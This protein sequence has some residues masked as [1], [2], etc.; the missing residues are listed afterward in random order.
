MVRT[1]APNPEVGAGGGWASTKPAGIT[2]KK[3]FVSTGMPPSGPA[4][5]WDIA[6]PPV[7]MPSAALSEAPELAAEGITLS[8]SD[9]LLTVLSA[10]SA[11]QAVDVVCLWVRMKGM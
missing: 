4:L 10:G 3:S 6:L 7:A 11:A 8:A 1:G 2:T 9:G 5:D